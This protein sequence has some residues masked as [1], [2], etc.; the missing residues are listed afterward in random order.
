V[1]LLQHLSGAVQPS[2][3]HVLPWGYTGALTEAFAEVRL[4][5]AGLGG[6]VGH[7]QAAA[8]A[9]IDEAVEGGQVNG[10]TERCRLAGQA[11]MQS[12]HQGAG[13]A[14]VVYGIDGRLSR[15]Q[16]QFPEQEVQVV[17]Q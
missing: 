8:Q 1:A 6:Q 4:A 16:A 11:G 10:A 3:H 12:A 2:T 7:A 9:V 17:A 13:Q 5:H 15:K 14:F